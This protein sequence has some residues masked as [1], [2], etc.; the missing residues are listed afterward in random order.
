M[1]VSL[2]LPIAIFFL[3]SKQGASAKTYITVLILSLCAFLRF[4]SG[5]GPADYFTV[6]PEQLFRMYRPR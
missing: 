1:S 3:K 5:G 6:G 2:R 4:E